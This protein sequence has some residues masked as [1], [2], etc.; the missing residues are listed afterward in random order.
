MFVSVFLVYLITLSAPQAK[1]ASR[2]LM[3]IN[4]ALEDKGNE[5]ATTKFNYFII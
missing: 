3:T 5:V 1:V 2:D 4:N